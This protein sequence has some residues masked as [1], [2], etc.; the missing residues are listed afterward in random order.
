[1]CNTKGRGKTEGNSREKPT[2]AGV[3]K[4][5]RGS[6]QMNETQGKLLSL[7]NLLIDKKKAAIRSIK[8]KTKAK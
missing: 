5:M 1:M 6:G 2:V 7:N 3:S 8:Q 4:A